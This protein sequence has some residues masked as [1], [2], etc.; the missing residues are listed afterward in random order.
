MKRLR[1]ILQRL[2]H[3]LSTLG[4]LINPGIQLGKSSVI[5]FTQ[6]GHLCLQTFFELRCVFCCLVT[7]MEVWAHINKSA[8]YML[9]PCLSFAL[10]LYEGFIDLGK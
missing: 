4:Q 10:S 5:F 3:T 2:F 8:L 1:T 6:I 7:G 9:S